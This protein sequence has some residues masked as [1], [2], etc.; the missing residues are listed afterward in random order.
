VLIA[1]STV[2]AD[3][4]AAAEADVRRQA[5]LVYGVDPA[6]WEL[7][8]SQVITAALPHQPPPLVLRRP[9]RLD[10]GVFVAGDHRD[11][12]SI[13]GALVSGRRVADAVTQAAR[14]ERPPPDGLKARREIPSVDGF[15]GPATSSGPQIPSVDGFSG[16]A[17]SS[18][19]QIPSVDGFPVQP[20]A[21]GPKS[22]PWTGFLV[23]LPALGPKS[24]PWTDS[25]A[26]RRVG[27]P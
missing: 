27:A 22:H 12:A 7:I 8:T 21:L 2:A 24:R 16:P 1:S 15:S 10:S 19:P 13:Q 4:S 23:R 9:A 20:P 17:T 25:A 5:G 14:R 3:S 6:A 18:G 26:T 11:T